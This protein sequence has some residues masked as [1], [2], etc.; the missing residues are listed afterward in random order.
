MHLDRMREQCAQRRPC[1]A[2]SAGSTAGDELGELLHGIELDARVV[3]VEVAAPT[4]ARRYSARPPARPCRSRCPRGSRLRLARPRAARRG[5]DRNRYGCES[6]AERCR[7]SASLRGHG[8]GI[9]PAC[10]ARR[11][12]RG[13]GYRPACASLPVIV[14]SHSISM[15]EKSVTIA[16]IVAPFFFPY[17]RPRTRGRDTPRGSCAVRPWIRRDR[18][19]SRT[20]RSTDR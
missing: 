3:T 9:R 20:R 17:S 18:S 10:T 4:R 7:S 5:Q 13:G 11:C 12:H 1:E 8:A 19:C 14:F 15:R 2:G 6:R 16:L